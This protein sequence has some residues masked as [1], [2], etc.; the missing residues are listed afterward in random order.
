MITTINC[1][2]EKIKNPKGEIHKLLTENQIEIL[3]SS[4]LH[5]QQELLN[6]AELIY[7]ITATLQ[8]YTKKI[9][10]EMINSLQSEENNYIGCLYFFIIYFSH[11]TQFSTMETIQNAHEISQSIIPRI[12]NL[13]FCKQE[14]ISSKALI[15][16]NQ[17]YQCNYLTEENIEEF[18]TVS[19][20]NKFFFFFV[21]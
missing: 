9:Q 14:D 20:K 10:N 2:Q 15:C 4:L 12:Q 3:I 11:I 17:I 7:Y 21:F 1:L 18:I 8:K 6:Q 16:F 5:N 19:F 13:L